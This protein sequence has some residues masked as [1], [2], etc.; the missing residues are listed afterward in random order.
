MS[1]IIAFVYGIPEDRYI[2]VFL[3]GTKDLLSVALICA[4]ARGIQVVM[5]DG[6]ITATVLY[7]GEQLLSGLSEGIFI[8]VTYIFYIPLSFLIPSTSGL[9]A[10][11]MG[12]MAPLGTFAGVAESLII[13]AYQSASGLVNLIT[14]TSGVVM[15]AM[16]I[17]GLEIT[18]WWKFM[19][20]L[21]VMIFAASAVLL[22]VFALLGM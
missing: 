9:A 16:A 4:V 18:T 7:W 13:T 2:H 19:S 17:A 22:V 21:L 10:A 14:P 15:G 11:T 3:E 12:I 1:I 8:V 6:Q 5:N 20:K